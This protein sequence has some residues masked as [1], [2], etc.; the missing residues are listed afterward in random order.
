MQAVLAASRAL[1]QEHCALTVAEVQGRAAAV[2][3]Q[4]A[5]LMEARRQELRAQH[6]AE[7]RQAQQRQADAAAGLRVCCICYDE[8]DVA[9]GIECGAAGAAAHFTCDACFGEHVLSESEKDLHDLR[10][11]GGQVF[12]PL[13]LHGCPC[14][15]PYPGQ[16]A[17]AHVAGPVFGAFLQAQAR[18]AEQVLVREL[19]QQYEVRLAAE[20]AQ[21]VAMAADELQ[22]EHTRRHVVDRLLTLQCPRCGAAFLDFNGCFALTC[23]RCACGF[24]AYCLADCG[25]DAHAHVAAC[26]HRGGGESV[27]GQPGAFEAAQ[28]RR[29]QR[30]VQEYLA[31]L[32][33][34]L[35]GRVV[36][37]C[38]QD[39]ADL[40]L[41]VQT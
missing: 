5:A 16:A 18:L 2:Q 1:E 32:A 40:N 22:V 19:E 15:S 24:C 10:E 36:A 17:A 12:C 35:R 6:E 4:S 11:R 20:R 8:L 27:F 28:R 7:R 34:R 26:P 3:E 31:T 30:M 29:R 39:F 21:L 37:A 38:A 14:A 13:R 9:G 23:H 33:E 25:G 41:D